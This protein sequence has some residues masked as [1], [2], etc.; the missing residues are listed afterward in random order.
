MNK[1]LLSSCNDSLMIDQQASPDALFA[2][3]EVSNFRSCHRWLVQ[4]ASFTTRPFFIQLTIE[5]NHLS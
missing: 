3:N 1:F 4:G 2:Y 5:F